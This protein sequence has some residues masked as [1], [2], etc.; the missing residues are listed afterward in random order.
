ML[1]A[2]LVACGGPS[3][4]QGRAEDL[5]R[6]VRCLEF[7][8]IEYRVGTAGYRGDDRWVVPIAF[9]DGW[10]RIEVDTATDEAAPFDDESEAAM[11][12][13]CL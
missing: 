7:K 10:A 5:A 6:E 9:R 13:R 4:E 8:D 11:R 12:E 3:D 1:L 2:L